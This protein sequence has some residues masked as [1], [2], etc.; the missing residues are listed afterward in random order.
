MRCQP[1][2]WHHVL[3]K[4]LNVLEPVNRRRIYGFDTF[5]GS[6]VVKGQVANIAT[7]KK[8]T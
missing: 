3:G 1:W 5:S 4:V 6:G 2:L 7:V 8:V